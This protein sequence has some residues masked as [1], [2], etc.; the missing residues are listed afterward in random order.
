MTQAATLIELG[1][2]IAKLRTERAI[3]L[4]ALQSA[5]DVLDEVP[6]NCVP[7]R[8]KFLRLVIDAVKVVDGALKTLSTEDLSG[9]RQA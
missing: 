3:L 6:N 1:I 9:N 7:D 4:H 2:E 5:R 8:K